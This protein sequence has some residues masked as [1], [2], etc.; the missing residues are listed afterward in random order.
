MDALWYVE[1]MQQ[2]T[3]NLTRDDVAGLASS[4]SQLTSFTAVV[5]GLSGPVELALPDLIV[6]LSSHDPVLARLVQLWVDTGRALREHVNDGMGPVE[7]AT[8][9]RVGTCGHAL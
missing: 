9:F 8:P 3:L 6:G 5:Q 1:A 7:P 2:G 4:L